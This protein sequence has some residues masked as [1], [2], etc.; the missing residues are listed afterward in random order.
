MDDVDPISYLQVL[1][2]PA[3]GVHNN[4]PLLLISLLIFCQEIF[5]RNIVL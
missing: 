5:H 3:G 1:I 2:L 4:F